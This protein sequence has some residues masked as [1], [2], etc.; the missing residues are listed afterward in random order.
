MS[1]PS[2]SPQEAESIILRYFTA[3]QRHALEEMLPLLGEDMR[4]VTWPGP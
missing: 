3:F 1:T 4:G 2:Q